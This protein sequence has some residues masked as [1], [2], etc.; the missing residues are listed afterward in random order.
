MDR[1]SK[2]TQAWN[3]VC[4]DPWENQLLEF[5]R[6]WTPQRLGDVYAR[7]GEV[8]PQGRRTLLIDLVK[9]DLERRWERGD[10]R[11]LE[12]YLTSYSEL[13]TPETVPAELVFLEYEV[14][15]QFGQPA[16]LSDF[17]ER[18]P[19]QIE[20]LKQKICESKTSRDGNSVFATRETRKPRDTKVSQGN[21]RKSTQ[22][23]TASPMSSQTDLPLSLRT[24]YEPIKKLGAGAMGQ[25][26]LAKDL[27]LDREVALK[28]PKLEG[29]AVEELIERFQHEAQNAAKLNHPYLCT[30]FDFGHSEQVTYITM[31]YIEGKPLEHFVGKS[32]ITVN[33]AVRTAHKIAQGLAHAHEQGV[34]HRDMK[35]DN[36]MVDRKWNPHIMD[37]GLAFQ[38]DNRTRRTS[39]GIIM[40]TPAYMSPEQVKAVAKDVGPLVDVYSLGVI[41]YEMLTGRLPF[42]GSVA[43]TLANILTATPDDPLV[44][45]PEL[46][47]ELAAYCLKLM[48]RDPKDRPQSMTEVVKTLA[49]FRKNG[50]SKVSCTDAPIELPTATVVLDDPL[51]DPELP[52]IPRIDRPAFRKRGRKRK[53]SK[54]LKRTL[55]A[56][57]GG[58]L[59]C[60]GVV[61]TIEI[62]GC[63]SKPNPS[64]NNAVAGTD[65]N[66]KENETEKPVDSPMEGNVASLIV[67]QKPEP[68][69]GGHAN[70]GETELAFHFAG[71]DW[72]ELEDVKYHN[73][74][75]W[76]LEAIVRPRSLEHQA[77]VSNAE[78]AGMGLH[79][80]DGRWSFIYHTGKDYVIAT[81]L[82]PVRLDEVV[83]VAG[84]YDGQSI[85]LYVN[86]RL[87][88]SLK[89]YSHRVSP[90][91][92]YIG[93]DPS[94]GG[95]LQHFFYGDI[96]AVRISGTPRYQA[97]FN[98]PKELVADQN[99]FALY[100]AKSR[101]F[102]KNVPNL[103]RDRFHGVCSGVTLV[104]AP[105]W[106]PPINS[107]ELATTNEVPADPLLSP[108]M[109]TVFHYPKKGWIELK[110]LKFSG[111]GPWTIEAIVCLAA[112]GHQS[113]VSNVE[114][115]GLGL[116]VYGGKWRFGFSPKQGFQA[117]TSADTARLNE[118]VHLA[119]IYEGQS[120]SLYLNGQFQQSQ[121]VVGHDTSRYNFLIGADPDCRR[122]K[123]PNHFFK[124]DIHA[125][126]IS[127]GARYQANFAPPNELVVDR[128]AIAVYSPASG[129]I[130]STVRNQ[131]QDKFHG[132][133]HGVI[134]RKV[135]K[136]NP[137]PPASEFE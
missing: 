84:A 36:I 56:G 90:Y 122:C 1:T 97:D 30:I 53:K 26:F 61:I 39:D 63:S 109:T 16:K 59:L 9:I 110:G 124:G 118:V 135:P 71:N 54:T 50:N 46:A 23:F 62:D 81:S 93:S 6:N 83:H 89:V 88:Q 55:L 133:A 13:G 78:G 74:V 136:W 15:C 25:V 137:L 85:S 8:D 10:H 94:S 100:S 125:V 106:R 104:Q 103:V 58:M 42:R 41:L 111:N 2:Q 3:I 113:F 75:P 31:E 32:P 116:D 134:L 7:F 128:H 87:Q 91:N 24:R 127:S 132:T 80:Q 44:L 52:E 70:S 121:K 79:I 69:W 20:L 66:E 37:F 22:G 120:I 51:T 101:I 119:G 107:P 68:S 108:A 123:D 48:A 45:R 33:S 99:T 17:S 49:E 117:A 86:G 96:Y 131:A 57:M 114:D 19:N 18:F 82:E 4:R 12:S 38:S 95:K 60:L 129:I 21:L 76:T 29:D 43:T 14:R 40:G 35:P 65:E 47:P 77:I 64:K 112:V 115:G 27:K 92:F 102:K 73:I 105:F 98:P 5:D 34:V 11:A 67:G 28:I 72:I 126:R 130:G